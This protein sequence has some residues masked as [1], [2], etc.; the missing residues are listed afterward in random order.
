MKNNGRK[1]RDKEVAVVNM[2]VINMI[3]ANNF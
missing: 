1:Y 2:N 3:Y